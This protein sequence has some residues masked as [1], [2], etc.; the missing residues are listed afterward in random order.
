MTTEVQQRQRNKWKYEGDKLHNVKKDSEKKAVQEDEEQEREAHLLYQR[1][2]KLKA[3]RKSILQMGQVLLQFSK[4]FTL[5]I[6]L[7]L[8]MVRKHLLWEQ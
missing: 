6:L 1:G 4:K 5:L 8:I 7:E 3:K 2:N